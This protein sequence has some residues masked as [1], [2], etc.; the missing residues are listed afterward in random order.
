M[1]VTFDNGFL[2]EHA[3]KNIKN[4]VTETNA[5]HILYTVNR[6]VLLKLYKLA[7]QESSQFCSV[8]MSGIEGCI[9]QFRGDTP[10][11]VTGNGKLTDYL[12]FIPELFQS[13]DNYYFNKMTGQNPLGKEA[14]SMAGTIEPVWYIFTR[15]LFHSAKKFLK[16]PKQIF[17]KQPVT[18]GKSRIDLYDYVE[19]SNERII[20]IIK[21]EMGWTA[22]DEFEH[23]DCLLHDMQ[24]YVNK[25]KFDELSLHT[26]HRSYLV[27]KGEISRE[28]ALQ[29]ESEE[30]NNPMQPSILNHFLEEIEMTEDEFFSSVKD[31]KKIDKF[32]SRDKRM[33]TSI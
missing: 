18:G 24:H 32:R 22:P 29:L 12:T 20:E 13:G 8:C 3:K 26:F 1:C 30:L 10:L 31:W 33:L 11:V 5:D 25:L 19:I 7:L 15:K 23:M 6:K 4:A 27:R 9:E 28:E 17:M 2:S 14:G 16:N 21:E